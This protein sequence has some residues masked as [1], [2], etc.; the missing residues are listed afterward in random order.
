MPKRSLDLAFREDLVVRQERQAVQFKGVLAE[1]VVIGGAVAY[2]YQWVGAQHYLAIHD[3]A[4]Q[5]GEIRVDDGSPQHVDDLLGRISYAPQSCPLSGWASTADRTNAF[6]SITF[7]ADLLQNEL[8]QT[9]L[10][11]D[12]ALI[13]F[14]D[15]SLEA[16][17]WKIDAALRKAGAPDALYLETLVL[18]ALMELAQISD[19]SALPSPE[20]GGL[21]ALNQKR[22]KEF[23]EQNAS[24]NITLD[25]MAAIAGLSRYHFARAFK[26]TFGRS[27]VDYVLQARVKIAM[28][29]IATTQRP[30]NDIAAAVGFSSAD[31][32][33]AAFKKFTSKTPREYRRSAR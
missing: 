18:T 3:I 27:P 10:R 5:G 4:L 33:T 29:L 24:A 23:V 13:H 26:T 31:R 15:P 6:T 19:E 25:D 11:L 32:F 28:R 20:P 2:D 7:D 12:Q 8:E 30:V 9:E 16:T 1:R 14:R 17:L 21:S 22:L